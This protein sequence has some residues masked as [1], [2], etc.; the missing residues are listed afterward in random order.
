M[1]SPRVLP[2][3][4]PSSKQSQISYAYYPNMV[5]TN[6]IARSVISMQHFLYNS[7]LVY[8]NS[9]IHP[10]FEQAV[11]RMF[12]ML[13]GYTVTK[14]CPRNSTWFIRPFLLVRGQGLGTR[15]LLTLPLS[16]PM[17]PVLHYPPS[18]PPAS[19]ALFLLLSS[20]NPFSWV[21]TKLHSLGNLAHTCTIQGRNSL[22]VDNLSLIG[23]KQ[24]RGTQFVS[25][26]GEIVQGQTI[27]L[28]QGRNSLGV[29]NLSLTVIPR[30]HKNRPDQ[31]KSV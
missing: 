5:R 15:P 6:E 12:L 7:K 4:K 16:F 30:A 10:L 27:C 28:L 20:T 8:L 22:G 24:F 1:P 25:Y 26:R 18:P 29:H 2:S 13:L 31:I 21:H 9:I 23:E 3:E 17:C 14:A 11:H 19:S